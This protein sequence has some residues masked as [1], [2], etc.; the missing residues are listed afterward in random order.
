[1]GLP[2]IRDDIGGKLW[3]KMARESIGAVDDFGGRD[4]S[5]RSLDIPQLRLP[6]SLAP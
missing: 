1:M 6:I 3:Q 5:S 2:A 4:D